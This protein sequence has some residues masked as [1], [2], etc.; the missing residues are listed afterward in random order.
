MFPRSFT[1]FWMTRWEK[2]DDKMGNEKKNCILKQLKSEILKSFACFWITARKKG[3]PQNHPFII[4][5]FKINWNL[6]FWNP[7]FHLHPIHRWEMHAEQGP[8][9]LLGT[10]DDSLARGD[11]AFLVHVITGTEF[12]VFQLEG[13][14]VHD[15]AGYEL[16][17]C[18]VEGVAGSVTGSRK[19]L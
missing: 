12:G 13:Y 1:S 7:S 8:A 11:G 6:K 2:E 16:V 17:A 19:G 3:C 15:V 14:A 10:L 5:A 9:F 4:S 18:E